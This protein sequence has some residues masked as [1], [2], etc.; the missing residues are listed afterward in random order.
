MTLFWA[1]FRWT[2]VTALGCAYCFIAP[3]SFHRRR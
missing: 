3:R 1:R 2:I